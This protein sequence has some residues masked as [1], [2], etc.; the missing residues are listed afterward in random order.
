MALVEIFHVVANEFALDI[1]STPPDIKE[2]MLVAMNG[3]NGV[4]RVDA[5]TGVLGVIGIAGDTKSSTGSSMPGIYPGWQNRASDSMD[6]TKAS[7]KMTVYSG[8]GA[9]ATDMYVPG[10]VDASKIGYFLIADSATGKLKYGGQSQYTLAA[11]ATPAIAQLTGAAGSYP[12][13]VP[14]TDLNGDM[15]LKGENG[16]TYIVIK[17][18]V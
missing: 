2:G 10:N 12:S 4:R 16:D 7:A 9:F 14:G 13:G 11:A 1:T 8:G 17:L 18:L 3:G 5:V 6:E 15:K